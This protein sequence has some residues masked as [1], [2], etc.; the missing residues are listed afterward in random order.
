M[1]KI[2]LTLLL[3]VM[4]AVAF[5]HATT[6]VLLFY[7]TARYHHQSIPEDI[8]A[9]Q[10]L[11]KENHFAVDTTADSTYFKE[12]NL[13]KYAAIV[14][15]NT[16]GNV[17]DTAQKLL[18][19]GTYKRVVVMWVPL[20]IVNRKKLGLVWQACRCSVYQSSRTTRRC[21]QCS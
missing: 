17:L 15:L 2:A 5:A 21:D 16:S 20:R 6:R 4:T 1:K 18:L 7:K 19:C 10:K 9:I 14:F 11:G 8:A 13:K 3:V 12:V